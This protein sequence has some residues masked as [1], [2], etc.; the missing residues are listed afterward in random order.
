MYVYQVEILM[1]SYKPSLIG[2]VGTGTD[3]VGRTSVGRTRVK[4]PSST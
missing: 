2:R 1:F 4:S 3:V